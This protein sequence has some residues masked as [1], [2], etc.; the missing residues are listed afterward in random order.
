M[1][2]LLII[3]KTENDPQKA[4]ATTSHPR[5]PPSGK[6]SFS[7]SA[8]RLELS[9][10]GSLLSAKIPF[11]FRLALCCVSTTAFAVVVLSK[12][13]WRSFQHRESRN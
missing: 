2:V 11:S 12:S 3:P 13:L 7:S 1:A 4:P 8:V 5:R 10:S 6:S 9:L